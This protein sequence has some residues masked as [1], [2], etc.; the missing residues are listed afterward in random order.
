MPNRHQAIILTNADPILR[1]INA[2]PG[3]DELIHKLLETDGCIFS[4]VATDV[5]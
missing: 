4:T 2:A 3:G 5:V 1:H